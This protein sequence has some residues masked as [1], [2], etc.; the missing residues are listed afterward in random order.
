MIALFRRNGLGWFLIPIR[1]IT[2]SALWM[3]S[4]L[5][6][7]EMTT[8]FDNQDWD[9]AGGASTGMLLFVGIASL[10][11]MVFGHLWCR[12][13]AWPGQARPNLFDWALCAVSSVLAVFL[14]WQLTI[15]WYEPVSGL[16]SK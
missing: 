11:A 10:L 7:G 8:P 1:V 5:A 4:V 3:S 16:L 6:L 15:Y 2:I 9:V 12:R 14:L 13:R